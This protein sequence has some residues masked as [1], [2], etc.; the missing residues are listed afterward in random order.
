MM[1]R[2]TATRAC[3]RANNGVPLH[4]SGADSVPGSIPG[5]NQKDNH[6]G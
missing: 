4:A 5:R 2:L 3:L 6:H 1:T